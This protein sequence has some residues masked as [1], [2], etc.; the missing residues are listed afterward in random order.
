MDPYM[1]LHRQ[2]PR[3]TSG[4][5]FLDDDHIMTGSEN[6]IVMLWN[7]EEKSKKIIRKMSSKIN[8]ISSSENKN[9][10]IGADSGEIVVSNFDNLSEFQQIQTGKFNV[11]SRIWK[12][13]WLTDDKIIITGTY[14]KI[15]LFIEEEGNWIENSLPGTGHSVFGLGKSEIN[16]ILSTGD[17]RGKIIL[18]LFSNGEYEHAQ[19][20]DARQTIQGIAWIK[21]E[22][23]AVINKLGRIY[24]YE[25]TGEKWNLVFE[26]SDSSGQ[27]KSIHIT[28]NGKYVFAATDKEIIQF[29]RETHQ[30]KTINIRNSIKLTSY[31]DRLYAITSDGIY[32]EDIEPV[33]VRDDI[34]K[35]KYLKISIVGHTGVGKTAL[36]SYIT[37]GSPGDAE[38][39]YGR[40]VWEWK[41]AE[42]GIE[43]KVLFH[44]HGGQKSPLSTFL[45]F[46]S[47]SDIILILFQQ[48]DDSTLEIAV[49]LYDLIRDDVGENVRI[50]FVQT[51]ID[52][53]MA[54]LDDRKLKELISAGYVWDNI[55][56]CPL[57]GRGIEEFKALLLEE[58]MWNNARTMIQTTYTDAVLDTIMELQSK[59]TSIISF[60]DFKK[61]YESK[62]SHRIPN[63]HLKF[64]LKNYN[65][66]GII[67]YYPE[68]LDIIIIYDDE[69]NDLKSSIP[70]YVKR[71][72]GIINYDSLLEENED[73]FKPYIDIIDN[74]YTSYEIAIINNGMRI[75]PKLLKDDPI[76]I[77]TSY[78]DYLRSGIE[79]SFIFHDQKIDISRIIKALSEMRGQCI[80]A[81]KSDALF[82]WMENIVLFFNINRIGN[83]MDG[84]NICINYRIGGKNEEMYRRREIDFNQILVTLF[85]SYEIDEESIA[86]KKGK[87][88]REIIYEVALSCAGEQREF[89]RTV[90]NL[91]RSEGIRVFYDEFF[92]GIMWGKD[93][94]EYLWDV[95]YENSEY[96]M[97]FISNEYVQKAWPTFERKAAI[98]RDIEELGGYILPVRFDDVE[99]PGLLP[100]IKY[101][102]VNKNWPEEGTGKNPKEIFELYIREI[103]P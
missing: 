1:T 76:S 75:F 101:I 72:D 25:K 103:T 41:P 21:D 83:A 102:S 39:T 57:D 53:R 8:T 5:F 16:N 6:G 10:L 28:Q 92:E 14:G 20:L 27:G 65:D 38:S 45:P 71:N 55:K 15:K 96:C 70:I 86:K 98:A 82:S 85:G 95:Y 47:D 22:V 26:I 74:I 67:D 93:L 77:D 43:K 48:N 19:K 51:Y 44:D 79:K 40:N 35:Y 59:N 87:K 73:E 49:N 31:E 3:L 64:L 66:Q 17:Y 7:L 18:W 69:Y 62:T 29:D 33:K 60:D 13:L 81:S 94:S 42:D 11:R 88:D 61:L 32:I 50:Y 4:E 37:T 9:I 52:Y 54:D 58:D 24:L 99:V 68:I 2:I 63:Y 91:F 84:F 34:V 80:Q 97:M 89:V 90:A 46:L 56:L 100:S 30:F 23:F 78:I 12:S 36:C